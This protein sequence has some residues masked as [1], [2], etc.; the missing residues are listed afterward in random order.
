[1]SRLKIQVPD[2]VRKAFREHP[3]FSDE[4]QR[5]FAVF[6]TVL[7]LGRTRRRV[8]IL[9]IIALLQSLV[10]IAFVVKSM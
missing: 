4:D 3:L 2:D 5:D 8:L 7:E 1:M 10:I 6:S 9:K